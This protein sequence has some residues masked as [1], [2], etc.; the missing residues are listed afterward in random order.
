MKQVG[1]L[2]VIEQQ[3][4]SDCGEYLVGNPLDVPLLQTDVPIGAHPDQDG[5]LL[6]A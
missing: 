4:A 3:R 6:A 2:G 1:R 5:D